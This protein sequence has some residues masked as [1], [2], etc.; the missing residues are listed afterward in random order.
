MEI[1]VFFFLYKVRVSKACSFSDTRQ[2]AQF[3]RALEQE[4]IQIGWEGIV[5][6]AQFI[7]EKVNNIKNYAIMF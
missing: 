6:R 3:Y 7:A 4:Y 1:K 5:L 2:I